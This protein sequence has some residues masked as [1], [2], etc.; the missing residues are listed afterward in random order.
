MRFLLLIG[1]I[2]AGQ[3][4]SADGVDI[5]HETFTLDNGLRV[6]VHTDRKAPIVAVNLW[7]HVGSK[8]ELPG[9][10]GFA[11]LFE[12][13]MFQGTENYKDEYFK[14]F[15]LVGATD[16]N[17]TTNADRTNY[18]ANVPTTALDLALWMASD[19]MGHFLGAVDQ[20]ALDE[21]RGVVQNEK[22]QGE[23]QPYGQVWDRLLL[24]SYPEGHRYRHSTI[25]SMADLNAATLAD[26]RGW[27]RSWYG[28]NNAV[29]VLAGDIDVATAKA[30]VTRYFGDIPA[31]PAMKQPAIDIP[32]RKVS[33]REELAD[34]VAQA[35]IYR[36]WNIP[37][38]GDVDLTRLRLLAQV[39]GGSA[40][41]R[42]DRR[43]VHGDKLAD[44][45]GAYAMGQQLAGGFLLTVDVK[46][47]VDPGKVEA[48]LDEEIARLLR[49][50]PTDDE[51][52]Q[53]QTVLRAGFVRQ[54]ER[55][56]GFG[57]KADVL[58]E[59]AVF[60]DDPSCFRAR[61][62]Q[63]ATAKTQDLRRAGRQW[64]ARASH[65]LIV[66]PGERAPTPDD[67]PTAAHVEA[68]AIA[69]VDP[70]YRTVESDVDRSKGPPITETFPD[71]VF[72]ALERDALENGLK[73][74]LARRAGL[75][76]VQMSMLFGGGYSAD[77]GRKLGTSS[78]TATM[79]DEGAGNRGA[80][81]FAAAAEALGAN[82]SSSASLDGITVTLSS[83]KDQLSPSLALYA[84]TILRPRFEQTEI[85][86]VRAQWLSGIAQEKTRPNSL[87][88]RLLPPLMYGA[89]HAY[90]IPFTG[91]GTE[92]SI[93]A[94]TRDDLTAFHRDWLRPDNA[95]LVIVGDTTLAEIKPL[96]ENRFGGWKAPATPLR[97]L[98]RRSVD[99]PDSPRVYLVDQP[100]ATQSNILV[101]Q[102]IPSSRNPDSLSF[103]LANDVIAGNFTSR[104]NMN[105][106]EDKSWSYGAYGAA[107]N[108]IGQ[109]PWIL[110]AP[111]QSDRTVEA[112]G[113]IRRELDEFLG[114]RPATAEELAKNR[115]TR[116]RSL[117]GEFE[118][119]SAVLAAIASMVRFDRP[120]DYVQTLKRR[121]ESIGDAK[122]NQAARWLEPSAMTWVIVGALDV[123]EAPVRALALGP[124]QV[125]DA[126]GRPVESG[127]RK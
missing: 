22:R 91:S 7:Y 87:A 14:P 25:G 67:K 5:P 3:A 16:M 88:Y 106:R 12:H 45:V 10:T 75:P 61:L 2:V 71:L 33:T 117:P 79:M 82:I 30:K 69:A 23:N 32:E 56:G 89:G 39:L 97:E 55:I 80:L 38:F 113:Q 110:S 68:P 19:A 35:R 9:K 1:F 50:G 72:P 36:T 103:D 44:S 34:R 100:G 47:G 111:V 84:D 86:R 119:G 112:I 118:T 11:H 18:F 121:I 94:L 29:L 125:L 21:Q 48:I 114:D 99:L 66:V 65:T 15:E 17:G 64:L 59:C 115:A 124:V 120:D 8:D 26:V 93:K 126:D 43:L 109:R 90:G 60:L 96:L 108:T 107:S 98:N 116:V 53:A 81:A 37:Q 31:G 102:V 104:I 41:S 105:L 95:T 77:V 54:I 101:G 49:E 42:L 123:I 62:D 6:V 20:A 83:L 78:F 13:L 76:L 70:K 122:A 40:T 92:G 27:F 46:Q 73:L 51:L 127:A 63:I 4:F 52:V 85:E 28:P 57:G 74:I 24:V 58:A